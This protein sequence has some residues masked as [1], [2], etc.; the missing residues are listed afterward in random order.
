MK[1]KVLRIIV[2]A[3]SLVAEL[4]YL[5]F[6]I[7]GFLIFYGDPAPSV[8]PAFVGVMGA[9]GVS[10][11]VVTIGGFVRTFRNKKWVLVTGFL[12]KLWWAFTWL[13]ISFLPL[14]TDGYAPT[15]VFLIT[16]GL[17]LFFVWLVQYYRKRGRQNW[18]NSW[19]PQQDRNPVSRYSGTGRFS[20]VKAEWCYDD[21][22]REY[23]E[24]YSRELSDLDDREQDKIYEYAGLWLGYMMT[25]LIQNDLHSKEYE[26]QFGEEVIRGVKEERITPLDLLSYNDYRL[27][28]DDIS[29]TGCDFLTVYLENERYDQTIGH[30]WKDYLQVIALYSNKQYCVGVDWGIYHKLAEKIALAYRYYQIMQEE[31][32]AIE[33]GDEY[34]V[35]T[36]EWE[37][38][39]AEL[40]VYISPGVSE[41]Y[42]DQCV[43][44]IMMMSEQELMTLGHI[45]LE[46]MYESDDNETGSPEQAL[47]EFT[48]DSVH[49]FRPYG[50]EPAYVIAGEA[51]YEEEH[52]IAVMILNGRIKKVGYR[53]DVEYESPWGKG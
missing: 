46:E 5:L 9:L 31:T 34:V 22:A 24:L 18:V 28:E 20:V 38:M 33:S 44:R 29:K 37:R 15:I 36:V 23:C 12:M 35:R 21:A 50:P 10:L 53:M 40:S 4:F 47:E 2:L 8:P 48:P 11:I 17:S 13:G 16:S 19:N 45:L 51:D 27:A 6:C 7:D 26:E 25:W 49:I 1:R 43:N 32:D 3:L 14:K 42:A 30:Y 41:E 52:G 39:R